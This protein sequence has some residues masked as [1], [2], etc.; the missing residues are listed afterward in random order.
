VGAT[1]RRLPALAD[2]IRD[3]EA[4]SIEVC[5]KK[6]A[7]GGGPLALAAAAD[8]RFT[9]VF[10]VAPHLPPQ[11]LLQTL[12]TFQVVKV[13]ELRIKLGNASATVFKKLQLD[14]FEPQHRYRV[15]FRRSIA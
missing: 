3:V 5:I 14:D 6:R 12:R 7:R 10:D 1:A 11:I 13:C 4:L 8:R 15:S 9:I 2:A